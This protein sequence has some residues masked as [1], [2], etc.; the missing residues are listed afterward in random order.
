MILSKSQAYNYLYNA[1][2]RGSHLNAALQIAICESSLNTNVHN[3]TG[4]DSRGLMQINVAS[5][6]N[7]QYAN[8]NL[9]DPVINTQVAFRIFQQW[10]NNFGA[11][12]CARTLG[13]VN[14]GNSNDIQNLIIPIALL[15]LTLY[16]IS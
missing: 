7:P 10:G 6:A 2:F 3:T 9:F 16:L 12:T 13:L 14:P 5:N 8:Y 15:G 11:W 4:E 1:G